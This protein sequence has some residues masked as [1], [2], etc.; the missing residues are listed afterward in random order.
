MCFSVE[1]EVEIVFFGTK[2]LKL[3]LIIII[4]E[5]FFG[6]IAIVSVNGKTYKTLVL[7]W[8]MMKPWRG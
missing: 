7:V 2:V 1:V 6:Y 3:S 8:V 5:L 4:G